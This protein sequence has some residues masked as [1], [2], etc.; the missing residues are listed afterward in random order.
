MI[1]YAM[2]C[3]SLPFIDNN[4]RKIYEKIKNGHFK[5][6]KTLSSEVKNLIARM[7]SVDPDKRITISEIKSHRWWEIRK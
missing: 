7:L 5:V 1:L 3:G 4:V 2:V 6:P